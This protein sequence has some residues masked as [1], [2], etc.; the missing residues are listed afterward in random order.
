MI[1]EALFQN[2]Y[3]DHKPLIILEWHRNSVLFIIHTQIIQFVELITNEKGGEWHERQ[4]LK[5]NPQYKKKSWTIYANN[6]SP[7]VRYVLCA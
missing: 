1:M 4:V 3:Y 6:E 2:F 5:Q 7:L